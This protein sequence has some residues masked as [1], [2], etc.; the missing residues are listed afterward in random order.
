MKTILLLALFAACDPQVDA[1]H[2]GTPLAQISGT[3]RS[4]RTLPMHDPE[5]VAVW[6]ADRP[7]GDTADFE[8]VA[9]A[10]TF[11]ARFTLTFYERPE[12]AFLIPEPGAPFGVAMIFAANGG[13]DFTD[14]EA[15]GD[16][17]LGM[18]T[19]HLLVYLPNDVPA[20]SRT[21]YLLRGQPTAGFHLYGVHKLTDAES[22]ARNECIQELG[23][24]PSIAQLYTICGG[25][26]HDD[27][28]PLDAGFE[29]PV[30]IE[31]VDDLSTIEAP[32]WN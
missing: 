5:I 13:T 32:N 18:A 4:K 11:P 8:R 12:P 26:T 19:D 10:G 2:Q 17:V 29:T 23:N 7:E 24:D 20:G 28:V 22:T 25:T 14:E 3:I 31:L 16:G 9:V 30:E 15:G 27:F 21:S 1:V 6:I